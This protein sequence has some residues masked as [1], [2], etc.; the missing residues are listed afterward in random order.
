MSRPNRIISYEGKIY[1]VPYDWAIFE[2]ESSYDEDELKAL[3]EKEKSDYINKYNL[4]TSEL[5]MILIDSYKL[6]EKGYDIESAMGF[7]N[8]KNME[9]PDYELGEGDTEIREIA[10]IMLNEFIEPGWYDRLM[11]EIEKRGI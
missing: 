9:M 5:D 11:I 4:A 1:Q 6:I 10:W 7:F 3:S 8:Q 2:L